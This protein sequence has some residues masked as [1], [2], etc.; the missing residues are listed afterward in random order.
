MKRTLKQR[1]CDFMNVKNMIN[2]DTYY[3]FAEQKALQYFK[4]LQSHVLNRTYTP[5]LKKDF[6][7][8]QKHHAHLRYPGSFFR[9]RK[10]NQNPN[11]FF[12]YIRW[13]ERKGKLE[14]YL[15]RSVSY[16]YMRDLGKDLGLPDT[17]K[18]VNK[19][20]AG[21]RKTLLEKSTG[22]SNENREMF[23][24]TSLYRF[25]KKERIES[26]MIWVVEKLK[27]VSTHIPEGMDAIHA[28]RKLI[29]MIG[30]VVLNEMDEM[31]HEGDVPQKERMERLDK[32]VRLGYSYGLSYPFV[33]DLLDS[34]ALTNEEK[35]QYSS[36]I[37][38]VLTRG[39]IPDP[40]DWQGKNA[41]LLHFIYL[42][43]REAFEYITKQLHGKMRKR[44]YE[45]A[46]V[47]FHSQEIDRIKDLAYGKYT[48]EELYIPV[49][50]KSASSRLIVRSVINAPEQEEF[51]KRMFFYGIY[52]QLADDFT[53]MFL[54]M[55]AG[56]VTPYTYYI[57]HHDKRP[58]LINPFELYWTVIGYLIHEVY[59]SDPQT[60]EV[61]FDRAINSLKR[62]KERT[63]AKKYNEIMKLFSSEIPELNGVIQF[64]VKKADDVDFF[65]KLI[66]D[67][68]IT[69]L[70]DDQE[71]Q[72]EFFE[73]ADTARKKINK[74][75]P[76]QKSERDYLLNEPIVDAANYI[77]ESGGKRLRPIITMVM[78]I[79]GYG[80][81]EES[82]VPLFR[83]LEYMHSASLVFDDLPSQDD[84]PLRRGRPTLHEVY[85]VGT[86]ELTGL[87]L[88]QKATEELAS[89]D[90]ESFDPKAILK[91]IRY[92]AQV[93]MDMCRGQ[94]ADLGT[95]DKEMTL[96]GLN[97]M[98]F[99]K[100]GIAFEAS[101]LMPAILAGVGSEEEEA[102]KRFAYYAGI[103]FQIKDDLLDVEGDVSVLGK[104]V[105]Q[106]VENLH[107]T[108]VTVLGRDEAKKAMWEHYCSAVDALE[109]VPRNT[110]FLKQLMNFIVTRER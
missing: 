49:I 110:S 89:L 43:L 53:D 6:Q 84:A 24:L 73:L 39:M 33:D 44:F 55:E 79:K 88:T 38:N 101:L 12:T 97:R 17:Q 56:S 94:L 7:S 8:W 96:E 31:E 47:F 102:L 51:N 83:A 52:N 68:M 54:D 99:F 42:E 50:L 85:D 1:L 98:S 25:A 66:R 61:I 9:N 57:K 34:K 14:Q 80:F 10:R 67:Q 87:F 107:A 41:D 108:F 63:G 40:F 5:I 62:F 30:G 77:L 26:T 105:G 2:P 95:V 104:P 35:K 70:K 20:A 76:L 28:Q 15:K 3:Q 71:G 37:R 27:K 23:T 45:Q 11:D 21:L 13:L 22:E 78:G 32:A 60:L 106:D 36:M 75:L 92:S 46:Y 81:K 103:A 91:V 64:M 69:S 19:T 100:T 65:D 86:A 82:I 58:D 18:R 4:T 74:V 16:V 48:N 59:H 29:K 90:P 93:T 109:E 72:K